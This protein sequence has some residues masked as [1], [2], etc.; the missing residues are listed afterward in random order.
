MKRM[1]AFGLLGGAGGLF[2]GAGAYGFY[3]NYD[4]GFGDALAVT[5]E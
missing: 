2:A 4:A 5:L 3:D 1:R